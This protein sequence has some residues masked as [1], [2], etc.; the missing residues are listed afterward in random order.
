MRYI[1]TALSLGMLDFAEAGDWVTLRVNRLSL[2]DA[3]AWAAEPGWVSNV[4]HQDTA[5]LISAL[6]GCP[7][8]MHRISLSL[9]PYDSILVAQYNGPRLEPGAA[10]LPEGASLRWFLVHV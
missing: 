8:P 9:A 1:G 6:L 7:V 3:Q 4:G 10:K 5:D 2:A